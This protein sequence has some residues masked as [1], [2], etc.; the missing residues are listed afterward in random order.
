MYEQDQEEVPGRL[1]RGVVEDFEAQLGGEVEYWVGSWED[2]HRR[3]EKAG[4]KDVCV[5]IG[6][7][8]DLEE[9]RAH[10]RVRLGFAGGLQLP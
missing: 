1:S 6:G 2:A 8:W 9:E 10:E 7:R 4:L 3:D 5:W